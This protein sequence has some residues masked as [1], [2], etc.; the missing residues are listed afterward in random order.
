MRNGMTSNVILHISECLIVW[1]MF[2][3]Q[4]GKLSKKTEKIVSLDMVFR[5][6]DTYVLLD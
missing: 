2:M 1:L 3:Y 5:Q 6:I 4:N